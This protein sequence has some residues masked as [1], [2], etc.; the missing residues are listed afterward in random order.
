MNKENKS[1]LAGLEQRLSV[2]ETNWVQIPTRFF[3]QM[4]ADFFFVQNQFVP[5]S[6]S[7][8][9]NLSHSRFF[10]SFWYHTL[11]WIQIYIKFYGA[12]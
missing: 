9:T 3:M 2:N 7:I 4:V 12:N 6:P 8:L 5:I 11:G 1:L 10:F